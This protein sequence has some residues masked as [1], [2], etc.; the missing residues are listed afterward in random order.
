MIFTFRKKKGKS[1]LPPTP[2]PM[3]NA[4]V[5]PRTVDKNTVKTNMNLLLLGYTS[6]CS[7]CG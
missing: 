4:F 5:F 1:N 3:K 6:K 7:V 2:K